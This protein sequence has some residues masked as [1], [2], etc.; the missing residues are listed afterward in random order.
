RNAAQLQLIAWQDKF[1]ALYNVDRPAAEE[2]QRPD[3]DDLTFRSFRERWERLPDFDAI[4][5]AAKAGELPRQLIETGVAGAE[6][7][8][9]IVFRGELLVPA[10]GEYTFRLDSDD[11]SRLQ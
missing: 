11:G 8:F 2:V 10:D 5:N 9:G 7:D 1:Q 4:R 3:I 6:I